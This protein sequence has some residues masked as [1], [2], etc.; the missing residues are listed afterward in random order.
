MMEES[1]LRN[2]GENKDKQWYHL[3]PDRLAEEIDLMGSAYPSFTLYN[4]DGENV[5]WTGKAVVLKEVGPELTSLK[6][7]IECLREFPIVFPRVYDLEYALVKR[8]CPHLIKDENGSAMLCYGNRLDPELNFLCAARVKNVVDYVC[9]FLARQWYFERYGKWLDG[10]PH[11]I[12]PFL[13]REVRNGPV[14]P[15]GL[16]PCGMTSLSYKSCHMPKVAQ[17]L[18]DQDIVPKDELR[19]MVHKIGRNDNCPCGRKM[20]SK[21]CCFGNLNHPSSK[22]FLLLKYPKAFSL[23]DEL[24]EQFLS[25]FRS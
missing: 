19:R 25:I 8:N 15:D 9:I 18:N 6:I 14:N 11:E 4:Q 22:F 23:N 16:C 10:Q 7:K 13:E 1:I 3:Y 2:L 24:R 12:L 20:K 17:Y 5:Y 21:K